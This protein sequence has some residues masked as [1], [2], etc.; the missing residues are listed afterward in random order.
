[1]LL[2]AVATFAL[3]NVIAAGWS[4]VA[5]DTIDRICNKGA[6]AY[7]IVIPQSPSPAVVAPAP[8]AAPSLSDDAS[9]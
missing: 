5:I 6:Y 8:A 9:T 4:W 3:L 2:S 1:M 7:D